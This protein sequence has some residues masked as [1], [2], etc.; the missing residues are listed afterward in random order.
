MQLDHPYEAKELLRTQRRESGAYVRE[1]PRDP[2]ACGSSVSNG[3]ISK[4]LHLLLIF[5]V[6]VKK[7]A[8]ELGDET[9][10]FG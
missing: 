2:M 4:N 6:R 5:A 7:V 1:Q 9:F 8:E 3:G 10:Y